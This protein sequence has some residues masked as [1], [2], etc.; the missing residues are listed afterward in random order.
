MIFAALAF[1]ACSSA[2]CRGRFSDCLSRYVLVRCCCACCLIAT[3]ASLSSH[4]SSQLPSRSHS[5]RNLCRT[6][7]RTVA[8]L[9][10]PCRFAVAL[11]SHRRLTVLRTA[12]TLLVVLGC[13]LVRCLF[14]AL[15]CAPCLLPLCLSAASLCMVRAAIFASTTLLRAASLL[16]CRLRLH[17]LSLAL[18]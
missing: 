8:S 6:S 10:H 18:C 9:S 11:L 7:R 2:S 13:V 14:V 17:T 3:F 15:F 4:S 1:V 5:R 12:T 16:I